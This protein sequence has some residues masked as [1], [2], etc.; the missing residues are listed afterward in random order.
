[1]KLTGQGAR[2]TGRMWQRFDGRLGIDARADLAGR[3]AAWIENR[4]LN[5]TPLPSM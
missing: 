5:V 2:V 3:I 1:M 4:Q